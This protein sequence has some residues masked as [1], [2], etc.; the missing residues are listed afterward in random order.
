MERRP[1]T[2]QK[3]RIT[4]K[5]DTKPLAQNAARFDNWVILQELHPN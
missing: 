2:N 1:K 3:N 5:S 4:N